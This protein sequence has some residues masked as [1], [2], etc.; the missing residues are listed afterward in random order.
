MFKTGT[1]PAQFPFRH[2]AKDMRFV[3]DAAIEHGAW[4]P[5]GN[6]IAGLDASSRQDLQDM[7]FAAVK[8]ILDRA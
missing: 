5:L 4:L 2:M 8:L 6:E 1:Y 3:V 7:D